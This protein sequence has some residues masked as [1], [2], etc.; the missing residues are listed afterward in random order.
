MP[1]DSPYPNESPADFASRMA[2]QYG[3]LAQGGVQ[4]IQEG[5]PN[6]RSLGQRGLQGLQDTYG[7][8]NY[9]R[10]LASGDS[11]VTQ[12]AAEGLKGIGGQIAD[13]YGPRNFPRNLR[14]GLQEVSEGLPNLNISNL[15]LG[16]S[17]LLEAMTGGLVGGRPKRKGKKG[18][19]AARDKQINDTRIDQY[20]P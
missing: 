13:T 19:R 10:N 16:E 1:K 15:P 9:M 12:K 8:E 6:V 14:S 3:R 11:Y 2:Q 18:K 7:P 5:L 17:N 20:R 4:E